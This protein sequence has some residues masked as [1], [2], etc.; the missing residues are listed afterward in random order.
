MENNDLS[1][2]NTIENI[3]IEI[4]N[5]SNKECMCDINDPHI[6]DGPLC[7]GA[8]YLD[9]SN[10]ELPIS[11]SL[12]QKIP[13]LVF[14]IPY[15]DRENQM[16][17]FKRQMTY[18]L[19]DFDKDDY[20]I[21]FIHQK[22]K[23]EFNRGAMKN[24]G[25]LAIRNIYPNDYK[26]ITFIFNDVD[27]MP[28]NKNTLHF[29]TTP[30]VV[31]HFYG[32]KHVL[33]GIVSITGGDFEKIRGFPNLWAWGFEDNLLNIRATTAG[34]IVD[35]SNF[36]NILDKNI[37]HLSDGFQRIVNKTEFDVYIRNT[38]EGWHSINNLKYSVNHE[39]WFIDVE[40]F[41]TQREI[42][43]SNTK[44]HDLRNGN[45]PFPGNFTNRR[46]ARMGM[47]I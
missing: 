18:I 41:N 17:L 45:R 42:N 38:I 44:I 14:I 10:N 7:Q 32:Y 37:I 35:R 36:Y 29:K 16:L 2:V 34:L 43:P 25:F 27:T 47:I 5:D 22:D 15:R 19:E 46:S 30:G 28:Y 12:S 1:E 8:P 4:I 9:L 23:R 31:K 21:F 33:G 11:P 40:S 13:S 26:N 20:K 6:K 3:T 24:I 39:D